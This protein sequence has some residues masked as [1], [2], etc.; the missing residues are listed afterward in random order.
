MKARN[1]SL[2]L[3]ALSVWAAAATAQGFWEKKQWQTW[4]KDE[5]KKMQE[6]SPWAHKWYRTHVAQDRFGQP[7]KGDTRETEQQI[8]YVI[9]LRSALPVRQAFIRDLQFRN[10]YDKMSAGE[11]KNFDA[12]TETFLLRKYDDVI[13]VHVLYGT[14]IQNDERELMR[15]WQSNYPEGT[16]PIE[17]YLTTSTGKRVSPLKYVAAK[18]GGLEFELIFPRRL[19]GE[20]LI[21]PDVK[22]IGVEFQHPNIGPEGAARVYQDFKIEKMTVNGA[23]LY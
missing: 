23:V 12:S 3:L 1:I 8:F 18:G 22:T 17:A 9:Q 16:V 13:V 14:N 2:A 5:C 15:F 6:D 10:K 20:S 21:T 19:N 4:S 7:T 11:K